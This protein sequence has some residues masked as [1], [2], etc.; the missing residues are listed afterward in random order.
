MAKSIGLKT[1]KM[2]KEKQIYSEELAKQMGLKYLTKAPENIE[3]K[4][5]KIIPEKIVK[6]YKMFSFG[7]DGGSIMVAM[8]N[9]QD[10]EARNVLNFLVERNKIP[11]DIYWASEEAFADI[12]KRYQSAEKAVEEVVESFESATRD[13]ELSIK[14]RNKRGEERIIIQDAPVSKLVQVIINHALE[15]ESSDIHIEP[16]GDEYRVRFRVDGMLHSS[17][18]LPKNVGMA[19]ISHIKILSNLKIDETRKPQDGRFRI[20]KNDIANSDSVDFRVSTL[21]VINGEKIAMRIL[22]KDDRVFDL[23]KLGLMGKNNTVLSKKIKETSG[24]I[25]ITGPT[26]SGKSTTLYSFLKIIN[27]EER[28][29]ITLEDP[30]EY[31]LDGV[32]QSQINPAIG[33]GFAD[34]LRSILRQDPNII[35]IGEIRDGETAELAIH[36]ALTG[37]L[38]FSTLHTNSAIS[39]IPRLVDMGVEP[40]LLSSSI[41]AVAAQRLVRKLCDNC[42]K[43]F[44]LPKTVFEKVLNSLKNIDT[45]EAASY[46]LSSLKPEDL[47]FF[48]AVG[49]D[50]CGKSGYKGRLAIYECVDVTN[51]LREVITEKDDGLLNRVAQKQ[52]MLNMRQDGLLKAAMGLTS[53]SEVERMTGGSL[54]VGEFEDDKG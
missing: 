7:K 19:I 15:G 13:R 10:L 9:P 43:E 50:E 26:G 33:Y 6:K 37:H 34:G 53:V 31:S 3:K 27:Q 17:L 36:A 5:L 46:G 12:L 11:F 44:E 28:N 24:I 49:C 48:K 40:F 4:Y 54:T 16:I 39:A 45:Q 14:K 23:N 21:P 42:K 52:G 32:N 47:R 25:L 2:V 51:E 38:V 30:V 18:V 29:I 8:A 22:T 20:E 35:M 41:N 1:K